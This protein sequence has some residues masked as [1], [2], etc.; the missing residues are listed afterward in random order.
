SLEGDGDVVVSFSYVAPIRGWPEGEYS[1]TISTSSGEEVHHKFQ[2]QS[3]LLRNSP[4]STQELTE[5]I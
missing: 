2:V 4:Q 5:R 3:T 1:L